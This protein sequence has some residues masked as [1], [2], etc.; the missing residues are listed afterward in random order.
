[1]KFRNESIYLRW[2]ALVVGVSFLC[3]SAKAETATASSNLPSQVD[4]NRDIRPILSNNC[5]E[6]HGPDKQKRKA[7]LRLDLKDEPFK[8]LEAGG[9]ALVRGNAAKSKLIERITAH[10]EEDRMPPSKTGKRLT[11]EQI[12]LIR[13]WVDQG[14]SWTTHWAYDAPQ[15][16]AL[17]TVKNENWPQNEIDRFVLARLEKE[18]IQPS[19][20]ADKTT[21]IR[22]LSLD[23]VGLPPTIEEVDAFLNEKSSGA[24]EKLVDRLLASQH[25]GERMALPWLDMARYADTSGY[26]SDHNRQMWLWRDWVINAFNQN[27]PF[28]QFTVEQLAGDLLPNATV[29][30]KIASGFNR[31]VMTTDEGGADPNEYL[32]KYIVDRVNTTATVWLGTTI[33][34]AECHDHKYDPISQKEFYQL[35]AF[36]HNVP[37]KGLDGAR[38][39]NPAPSVQVPSQEQGVQLVEHIKAVAVAENGFKAREAELPAAQAKWENDVLGKLSRPVEPDGLLA[40][41]SFDE[42]TLG[43][44]ALGAGAEAAYHGTNAPVWTEGKLGKALRFDGQGGYVQAG[45]IADFERTNSFSYGCWAKI[46]EKGGVLIAKMENAPSNRGFDLEVNDGKVGVRLINVSPDNTLEVA[47][48]E[49]LPKDTWLHLMV[50]YDGSSKAKGVKLYANGKLQALQITSDKLTGT[51]KNKA[52]VHIGGGSRSFHGVMDD[53]RFYNRALSSQEV[54]QLVAIARL[55]IIPIPAEKRA[56]EQKAELSKYFRENQAVDFKKAEEQFTQSRKAMDDLVKQIPS[57][58]VME[59]LSTPRETFTLVRGNFQTKGD[60]VTAG[61]PQFLPVFPES[62]PPNRLG[63]AKWLVA[64]S[65]PLTS[66]VTVNRFWQMV[67]GTGLVT[68]SNDFG[69]RGEL[70]SHPEL[71][72]WLATEFMAR[73]W[74]VKSMLKLMVMSAAY[75]QSSATPPQLLARDPYNRLLARSPRFRLDAE[76]IRDSALSISGLLDPKQ[77]GPSVRP[78]QPALPSEHFG[79]GEKYVPSKGGDL[80]RRGVYTYWKRALVYP[81]F[82]TFDAPTRETCVVQRPRT[83]TPLQSLVLMN[84][85]VY[86]EASRGLAQRVLGAGRMDLTKRITYAFRL[87]V[88][89]APHAGELETLERVYHQQLDNYKQDREAAAALVSIGELARP[90]HLETSELAAWTAIGNV[91][92]NL[93]ETITR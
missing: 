42:T 3:L 56:V 28:D 6:C 29:E 16:P 88:A 37:E 74:D 68:T 57:T 39:R 72:D 15:H 71:L 10:E 84:D 35:Y 91:L 44:D 58:M 9:Y 8:E 61:V 18:G 47:T 53:V 81:A 27:K 66:R 21:L 40:G 36:F 20:E 75:R 23:L 2:I 46:G 67:F 31:N 49:A 13:R 43:A 14:A 7:G 86:V 55:A 4:Y 73:K 25:F 87:A 69:S 80:Y 62:A 63:L 60:K 89:R 83:S 82:V 79:N 5:Y 92:L 48:R 30:Q 70:P 85:P 11:S 19:P 76:L 77:G 90:E 33:G 65:H 38:D 24:Y 22:R 32:T 64:P 51:I 54:D 59:E 1:M 78:Y 26:H 12:D 17:P 45:H 93:N 34:C 52:P 41:F 50:A